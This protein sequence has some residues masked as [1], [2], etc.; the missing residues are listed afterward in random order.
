MFKAFRQW[1][2]DRLEVKLAGAKAA[3]SCELETTQW[4]RECYPQ[5]LLNHRREIAETEEKLKQ[6]KKAY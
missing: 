3:L 1:R 5:V 2:I 6:L 4:T